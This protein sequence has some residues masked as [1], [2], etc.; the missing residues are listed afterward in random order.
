MAHDNIAHAEIANM[1]SGICTIFVWALSPET[2]QITGS[3]VVNY[4]YKIFSM[5]IFCGT[6]PHFS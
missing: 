2:L 5:P 6:N 3:M 4:C 1:L